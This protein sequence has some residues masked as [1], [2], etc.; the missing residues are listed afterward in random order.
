MTVPVYEYAGLVG[1]ELRTGTA[2]VRL[3][4]DGAVLVSWVKPLAKPAD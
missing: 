2:T 3:E 4:A 1:S